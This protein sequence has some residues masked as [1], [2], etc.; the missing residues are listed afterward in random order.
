MGRKTAARLLIDLKS[1]LELPDLSRWAT[2]GGVADRSARPRSG[3]R[4][5]SSA[6]GPTRSAPALEGLV[7]DLEVAELL[8]LALRELASR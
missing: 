6:T 7:E 1:R 8:T 3:R 2:C 5:P 4:W